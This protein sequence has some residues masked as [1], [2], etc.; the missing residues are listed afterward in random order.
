VTSSAASRDRGGSH[1]RP[2]DVTADGLAVFDADWTIASINEAG[3]APLGRPAARLAGRNIWGALP[4][5]TGTI[6]HSFLLPARTSGR[7]ARPAD[8]TA[9]GGVGGGL[10]QRPHG[11]ARGG[12][13]RPPR[14]A[15]AAGRADLPRRG[16][17]GQQRRGLPARGRLH[18]RR[19]RAPVT[20]GPRHGRA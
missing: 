13:L 16:A 4:E 11:P 6:F 1:P 10:G 2:A 15:G 12:G 7:P 8:G 14:S 3:A 9:V 19:S 5:L 20:P 17:A 18:E